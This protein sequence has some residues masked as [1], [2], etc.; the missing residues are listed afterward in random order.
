MADRGAARGSDPETSHDAA[1]SIQPARLYII[2]AETLVKAATG[3]TT[4]EIADLCGIGYQTI[5]PRIVAMVEKGWVSDTGERRPW[6]GGPGSPATTR[7][8]IVWQLTRLWGA[9]IPVAP[10][11]RKEQNVTVELSM[12]DLAQVQE[13][14]GKFGA[15]VFKTQTT[16]GDPVWL[17][18]QGQKARAKRAPRVIGPQEAAPP[19]VSHSQTA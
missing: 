13:A 18:V 8:S 14:A 1:E 2:I 12:E 5:T 6:K 15:C 16:D 17:S 3:L 9:P 10:K 11:G 19:E 4:H 7:L